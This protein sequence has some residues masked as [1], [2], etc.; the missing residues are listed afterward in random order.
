L[1]LTCPACNKAA[2]SS[3]SCTRCGCD[4][5]QLRAVASAAALRLAEARRALADRKWTA[6]L[7]EAE[8]SWRLRHTAESA[9]TAFLA[10]TA[11]ADSP[12]A[13]A[14]HRRAHALNAP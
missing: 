12:Q 11:A 14:W 2:Q 3:T 10:A 8:V 7:S 4:L 5:S 6:A 9:R 1:L 13:I